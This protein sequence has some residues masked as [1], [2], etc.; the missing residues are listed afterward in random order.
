MTCSNS[1]D[2]CIANLTCSRC[3]CDIATCGPHRI[4]KSPILLPTTTKFTSVPRKM[5][6]VNADERL[7]ARCLSVSFQHLISPRDGSGVNQA[8]Y[9]TRA[10]RRVWRTVVV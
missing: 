2:V 6:R 7:S 9:C 10:I 4:R 5:L 3:F 8:I 1:I